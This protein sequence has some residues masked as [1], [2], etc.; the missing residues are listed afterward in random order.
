[1]EG[2]FSNQITEVYAHVHSLHAVSHSSAFAQTIT[3]ESKKRQKVHFNKTSQTEPVRTASHTEKS[4]L[5]VMVGSNFATTHSLV[6]KWNLGVKTNR[7]PFLPPS[8]N[9]CFRVQEKKIV[10]ILQENNSLSYVVQTASSF[11][12]ADF[13]SLAEVE[14][15]RSF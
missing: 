2:N 4:I 12:H 1:M 11:S 9:C 6:L 3:H 7:T 14:R 8:T 13:V 15:E 5:Y 10:S